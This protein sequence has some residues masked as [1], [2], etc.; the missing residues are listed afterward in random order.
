[1]LAA[2]RFDPGADPPLGITFELR[3]SGSVRLDVYSMAGI[4]VRR[5]PPLLLPLGIHQARWDGRDERGERVRPGLYLLAL[6][7]GDR[8]DIRRVLVKPR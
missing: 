8:L 4:R 5:F 3:E 1:M 2:N 7:R 6:R